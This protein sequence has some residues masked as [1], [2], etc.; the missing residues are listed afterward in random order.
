MVDLSTVVALDTSVYYVVIFE[1]EHLTSPEQQFVLHNF[2]RVT[3]DVTDYFTQLLHNNFSF[4]DGAGGK[5]PDSM[6]FGLTRDKFMRIS[7]FLKFLFFFQ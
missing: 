6:D 1:F 5:Q 4:R 7:L 3:L 2:P